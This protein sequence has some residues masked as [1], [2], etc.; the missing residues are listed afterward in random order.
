MVLCN[1]YVKRFDLT[2]GLS[3]ETFVITVGYK[4][5]IEVQII[6]TTNELVDKIRNLK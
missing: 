4:V 3:F 1:L 6:F 5:C 2:K